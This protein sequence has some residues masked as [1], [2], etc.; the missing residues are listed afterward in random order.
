M[1]SPVLRSSNSHAHT[2][3]HTHRITGLLS[4]LIFTNNTLVLRLQPHFRDKDTEAQ[5]NY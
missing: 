3:H 4:H 1:V 5:G 2:I